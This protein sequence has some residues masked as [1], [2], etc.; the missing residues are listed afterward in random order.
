MTG[1]QN[2][3][4]IDFGQFL[5][6]H[7]CQPLWLQNMILFLC[8]NGEK[9]KYLTSRCGVSDENIYL[10]IKHYSKDK[11][12]NASQ[13]KY[14]KLKRIIKKFKKGNPIIET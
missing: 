3:A 9:V 2:G 6:E 5:V 8:R 12:T 11:Q 1:D 14:L 10:W 13:D 4:S 7:L